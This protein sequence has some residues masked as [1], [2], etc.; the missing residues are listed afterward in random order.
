MNVKS[1]PL[2][3][4]APADVSLD[5]LYYGDSRHLLLFTQADGTTTGFPIT[6]LY[7][8]RR[9]TRAGQDR[10]TIF[11]TEHRVT[12][13]GRMMDRLLDQLR[14]GEGFHASERPERYASIQRSE[15]AY[16]SKITIEP[17][18]PQVHQGN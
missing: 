17:L 13:E 8:V 4:A 16:I 1:T 10:L 9:E 14:I 18:S 5:S 6:W 12:L 11:L 7:Q 2:K 15:D 3:A